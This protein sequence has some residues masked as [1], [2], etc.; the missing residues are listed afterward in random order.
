M[1]GHEFRS[2][3]RWAVVAIASFALVVP[4]AQS[5]EGE[6]TDLRERLNPLQYRVTQEDGTEPPF[7][8]AYWDNKDEG[9]YVDIVSGEALFSS[10]DK[11]RSGTGWPSFVRPLVPGNIVERR[12][13][14]LL[15]P[16]IEVRSKGANSHLG[17]V[18]NDGPEPTGKRYCLNSAALRFIPTA[19]LEAEGYGNFR[20]HFASN[21]PSTVSEATAVFAGGCFWCTEA[22]FEKL[23]GI[24]GVRSG[25][26]GGDVDNPTYEQV[27]AG[28]TGHTE[29]VEVTYDPSTLSYQNLLDFFW[30]TIDPTVENQQFCDVGS[31]YRTAIFVADEAELKSARTSRKRVSDELGEPVYTEIIPG[32][33]FFAAEEYHQDYAKKNPI[34]YKYYRLRCGR[35]ARLAEIWE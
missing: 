22:D 28:G 14:K 1:L 2:A 3:I 31:Q 15:L 33:K 7:D 24:K 34:R 18:F 27:S 26:A 17:H 12:D 29:A 19:S 30:K 32:R 6:S 4:I 11:F 8:N 21:A 23:P 10:K 20:S 13:F 9:I 25:Y 35:D 5:T 16:R